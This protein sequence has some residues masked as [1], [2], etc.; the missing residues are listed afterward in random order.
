MHR[1]FS[2]HSKNKIVN[3]N[4]S[5]SIIMCSY[6]MKLTL[7]VFSL[8]GVGGQR[9]VQAMSAQGFRFPFRSW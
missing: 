8:C 1:L 2:F 3:A 4:T 9:R 6:K 7:P 5:K